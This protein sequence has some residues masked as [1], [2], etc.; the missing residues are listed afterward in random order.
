[1]CGI[2]GKIKFNNGRVERSEILKMLDVMKYRGP[3]DRGVFAEESAGLGHLRLS[4]IDLSSAGHQPMESKDGNFSIIFNG[5]V[6]NYP[7]L[8]K[9]LELAGIHFRTATDTEVILE[10]YKKWGSECVKKFNGMW[11]FA[12]LDKKDKKVFL[13]RDHFGIKPMFY[14]LDGSVFCFGSE[15]KAVLA[16][17]IKKEINRP[18]LY[19][20]LS[21]DT[22]YGSDETVFKNIKIL[23][24]AHNMEINFSGKPEIKIWRYWDFSFADFRRKYDYSDAVSAFRGLLTDSVKLRLRSD[25]P[26]GVCLSGGIDSSVITCI[27]SKTF[28]LKVETFSSSYKEPGYSEKEFFDEVNKECGANPNFIEAGA[29]DFWET[30]ESL[31]RHHD[32]PV[33]MPGAYSQWNV[34]KCASKKV[35]VTLDGQGADELLAG[36][37]VFSPYYL[38]DILKSGKVRYFFE[39]IKKLG[40]N[41]PPDYRKTVLKIL[42]PFLSSAKQAVFPSDVWQNQILSDNFIKESAGTDLRL[43]KEPK[44]FTSFLNQELYRNFV[45]TN[46]PMLLD[47]EDRTSMAFSIEARVPFL[48]HRLVEYS[49]GLNYGLKIKDGVM[50]YILREAFKDILPK[51]VYER[52]DKKGFP[53]P[54]EHWFRKDLKD[55]IKNAIESNEFGI[56]NILDRDKVRAIFEKHLSGKDYSRL[57]WRALNAHEWLEQNFR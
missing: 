22:V 53:T 28:G 30:L 24:P 49:F 55:G 19:R 37:K 17:G 21:R 12:V 1:M 11:S 50:K 34:F 43:K 45:N 2:A 38:A 39:E 18:F 46:L 31:V 29:E 56:E 51:K 27:L 5:E 47:N 32:K 3:D 10:A 8:K 33:R 48:D 41:L 7:E 23:P 14:Y 36:Y 52:K 44:I 16:S 35:T 20:F 26:V 6:Y 15:M 40:A 42:F 9:E 4:I 13:S 54:L 25:V 57:L